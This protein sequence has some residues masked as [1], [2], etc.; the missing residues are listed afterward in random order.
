MK[1]SNTP[2]ERLVP[3]PRFSE[4]SSSTVSERLLS[5]NGDTHQSSAGKL[6]WMWR[7]HWAFHA[8]TTIAI[9][10]LTVNLWIVNSKKMLTR[11]ECWD[12]F[13]MPCTFLSPFVQSTTIRAN[14]KPK[15]PSTR[16]SAGF[17][18]SRLAS[19]APSGIELPS[20]ARP[21]HRS[22]PPGRTQWR[23]A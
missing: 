11:E 4:A 8:L 19:T 5:E 7:W 17:H 10:A 14:T 2:Y 6:R 22:K 16:L 23:T 9:V 1:A 12:R 18:L 21:R 15:L 20:R 13:H 3:S